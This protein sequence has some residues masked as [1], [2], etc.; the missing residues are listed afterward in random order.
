MTDRSGVELLVEVGTLLS[1][2]TVAALDTGLELSVVAVTAFV[3]GRRGELVV[4]P[5]DQPGPTDPFPLADAEARAAS[6]PPTGEETVRLADA[7][8]LTP[9]L[10]PVPEPG[11]H[12]A[13]V[14][15]ALRPPAGPAPLPD[16]PAGAPGIGAAPGLSEGQWQRLDEGRPVVDDTSLG[17]P[18][19]LFP[20]SCAGMVIAALRVGGLVNERA[21][22][23]NLTASERGEVVTGACAL[24]GA[25]ITRRQAAAESETPAASARGAAPR[26]ER[27]GDSGRD[28]APSAESDFLA[29]MSHELRTP[30]NAILGF[31]QL[32]EPADLTPEESD[33]L[34]HIVRAGRHMLAIL[35]D[36][37]DV[38]AVESGHVS[39]DPE[40]ID[41]DQAIGEALDLIR[42]AAESAG[43][44][45]ERPAT[46]GL[47]VR[48]DRQRLRQ[49]L[50]NLL[51]NAVKYN[52][53]GGRIRVEANPVDSRGHRT[54]DDFR[55]VQIAVA[56]SGRGIPEDRLADVFTPFERIG[57]KDV[58]GT[59]LG[60]SLVKSLTTAMDGCVDVT[61]SEGAGST[62][63][64]DLPY[65]GQAREQERATVL[66]VEDD[67]A[68]VTLVQR[69]LSANEQLNLVVAPDGP[70]GVRLIEEL[71][72]ALVLLDVHLPDVE[73]DEI[74]AGIRSHTDP[75]RRRTP[76]VVVSADPTGERRLLDA[77]ADAFVSKPIENHLLLNEIV[78]RLS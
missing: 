16:L 52:R 17:G 1:A 41:L 24:L 53:P 39:L 2:P 45:I 38:E 28:A 55:Y 51:S 7:P 64:I 63:T 56:D 72:P 12:A 5:S 4:R 66:Y 34:T 44:A 58:G 59:G 46:D 8:G 48:A 77:G 33:N 6:G 21:V 74:L 35:N 13:A 60:L 20:V 14:P 78:S 18:A 65:A 62:F 19:V 70:S 49:V 69:V 29:R 37:L 36:A 47:R 25:A 68:N 22:A 50:L 30:L 31:A 54:D 76:V 15:S 27:D 11:E 61:S 23:D 32:L 57:V 73:G 40:D 42:P 9:G 26:A 10:P 75:D 3:G 67:P 71:R 43:L